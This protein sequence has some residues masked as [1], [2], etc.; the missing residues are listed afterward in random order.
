MGASWAAA[1]VTTKWLV[2]ATAVSVAGTAYQA[3]GQYQQGKAADAQAKSE[4]AILEH[5]ARIAEQQAEDERQA[6]AREAEKFEKEGKHFKATQRVQLARGGV[7]ATEGTPALLLEETAQE[8]ER[9]RLDILTEGF[10]RSKYRISEAYGLRYQG[11]A[12]RARGKNIKRG[13][14]LATAGTLLT[15]MGQAAYT[16]YKLEN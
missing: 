2:A 3:Y 9:E 11:S 16:K 7:L 6:A 10:R 12:A 5:N 8:L 14:T 1:S 4:Q 15:G 13:A